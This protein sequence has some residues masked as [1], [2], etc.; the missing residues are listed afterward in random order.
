MSPIDAKTGR[1]YWRSLEELADTEEFRKFVEDEFPTRSAEWLHQPNRREI[2][3]LMGASFALAGVSACTKQPPERIVPYV[4]Q[5]EGVTPGKPLFFAT[6]MPLNGY[7]L[8]VLGE[9][10]LGR[11]TKVEG[12]PDHPG[13]LGGS[14]AI[15]QASVLGLYD[16]DRSQTTIYRGR[17]SG[18]VKFIAA[19]G[20]IRAQQMLSKGAGLRILTRTVTSPTLAAQLDEILKAFPNARWYQYEPVHGPKADASPVYRFDK[21]DVVLSLDSDFLAS[22]PGSPRYAR[23]FISRRR[24]TEGQSTMNRLYVFEPTPSITG[25]VADHRFP[26]RAS[27]LDGQAKAIAAAIGLP[28]GAASYKHA[29]AI[30]RDLKAHHGS[31]IVIAGDW[32]PAS[33][34]RLAQ[35]MNEA[36][37]NIGN[38]VIYTDSIEARSE[39][40]IA[41]I[42]ELTGEMNAGKVEALLM[43]GGNPVYDAPADLNFGNALSKVPFRTHLGLYNDETAE[44]CDWHVNEA[45]YLESWSDIRAYDG[46]AT[47]LQPLIDP[48]YGGK[49]AHEVLATLTD[50]PDQTSHD[51]IQAYWRGRHTAEDFDAF[52]EKTLNAGVVP[53]TAAKP[54]Q[55]PKGTSETQYAAAL[56]PST[57]EL[58]FRPDPFIWDGQFANNGWLQELPKPHSRLTWD[59]PALISLGTAQRNSL[60]NGDIV[61]LDFGGRKL[62]VPVW[63]Q[64][65]QVDD[66]VTMH[67][68]FGRRRTGKVGDGVGFNAYVLRT[69]DAPWGGP[70]LRIQKTDGRHVLATTQDHHAMEGRNIVRSA[71]LE[72]YK[73]DPKFALKA[74]EEE[75]QAR[76]LFPSF[77]YNGYK[78]GMAI[79]QTACIG[80]GACVSACNAENNIPIVGKDQVSR[81][82]EMHWIR[83]DR[84][85]AGDPAN[86]ESLAQPMLCQM[87]ETAP[88]ELVCPVAATV[89][90]T[91]GLNQ[92]VY[93]R[94]VGTRY[95]SNNCPYKVRRFNFYLYSDWYTES[96]FGL[97]N[98]E[99]TVRS[100]GVM[101]K[102]TYCVQR[103]N[104]V[105]IEA[106]KADRRVHEGE[107]VTACQQACPTQAITF[108][109]MNDQNSRVA[110][111]KALPLNYTVLGELNAKPRTTYLA[112]VKNPNPEIAQG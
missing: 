100:R 58:I 49:T 109:D 31:S 91:E 72:E 105:K 90:S 51:I 10:H 87:C 81:G 25:S 50:K 84:Y 75:F 85:Y 12:N 68:G 63:I 110:K 14:T 60:Q 19:M 47:I 86:P 8:G 3:R 57:M 2:L 24:L 37:G 92:M 17:I 89:H 6:A 41:S 102:C 38:T 83:V 101:E 18:W 44:K 30:A 70:G 99:V 33:L 96:L 43:L 112:K 88:C 93:N 45:H 15:A 97:R 26:V 16:P 95:C 5:P 104:A 62:R 39:D 23:D 66:C 34:H 22:I 108:G 79:D 61:E 56:N 40:H 20:M 64:P 69:S 78:W 71:T 53:D 111:W 73:A 98:P 82:R 59:N 4:K 80:C 1:E 106:E 36:L 48:L 103:I 13:S 9:S 27:E 42:K 21:A 29:D 32:Q 107:I 55:P 28:V 67:L 11:P 76:S 7:G 52:W 94:C 35:A 77:E 65:G 54:A 74:S 46:T